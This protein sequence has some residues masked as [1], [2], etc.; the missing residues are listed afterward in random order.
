MNI[1][2]K[3]TIDIILANNLVVRF[4][5]VDEVIEFLN[6][7]R[8]FCTDTEQV[9]SQDNVLLSILSSGLST[10]D[11]NYINRQF[12]INQSYQNRSRPDATIQ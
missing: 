9:I 4:D 1:R 10:E 8:F 7:H 2:N 12:K 11:E 5:N 3:I 6:Q